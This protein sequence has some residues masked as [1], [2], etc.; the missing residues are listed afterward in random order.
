M[1]F[2]EGDFERAARSAHM[3]LGV[4]SAERLNQMLAD[5]GFQD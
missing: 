1:A 4:A 2:N 3:R 5:L